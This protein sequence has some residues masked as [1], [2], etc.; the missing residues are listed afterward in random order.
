MLNRMMHI[1]TFILLSLITAAQTDSSQMQAYDPETHKLKDGIFLSFEDFRHNRPV[2][3]ERIISK[4]KMG[5]E[6]YLKKTIKANE[7][8]H[9]FD[10]LGLEQSVHRL[11][12]WGFSQNNKL[13]LRHNGIF[14]PVP[15]LSCLSHFVSFVVVTSTGFSPYG[16][17]YDDYYPSVNARERSEMRH[18][19][20]D[21]RTGKINDFTRENLS[22]S[23]KDDKELHKAYE[24][25]GKRKKR[26]Q[27][28]EYL[29]RYNE[30]NPLYLPIH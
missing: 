3:I 17:Y 14:N 22:E 6:D 13:Y 1:C 11:A 29:Q 24:R 20:I 25:L 27:K 7:K 16:A 28:F 10:G 4:E 15:K 12:I 23:I 2:P 21:L 8:I 26:K 19:I 18:Y 9:F 5:D 30:R